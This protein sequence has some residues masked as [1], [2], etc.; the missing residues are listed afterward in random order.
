MTRKTPYKHPVKTH[1]RGGS[2]VRNYKRGKGRKPKVLGS[3]RQGRGGVKYRVQVFHSQGAEAYNVDGTTY[4]G[5]LKAGLRHLQDRG[6]PYRVHLKRG[7]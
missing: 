1:V 3:I 2:K 5:A 7:G 4:V 6:A